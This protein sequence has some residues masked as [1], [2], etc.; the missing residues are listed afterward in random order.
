MELFYTI[1]ILHNPEL[2]SIYPKF[3]DNKI[4]FFNLKKNKQKNPKQS[5]WTMLH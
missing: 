5:S 3:W 4:M 2:N 1:Y